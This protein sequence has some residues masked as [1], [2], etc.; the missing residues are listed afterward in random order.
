MDLRDAHGCTVSANTFT[1]LKTD[2]VR[3]GPNSGRIT[4]TGNNISNS[5]VGDGKVRRGTQ[6]MAAAGITLEGTSDVVI[7]GNIF[8][9]VR[10][11]AIELT[12]DASRGVVFA[13]NVLTDV[14]SDDGRLKDSL[15]ENNLRRAAADK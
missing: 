9:S 12:G 11:K 6:D 13:N 2:A 10:P 14:Q 3:I 1:I 15:I 4:V 5:Y 7:T 8:A